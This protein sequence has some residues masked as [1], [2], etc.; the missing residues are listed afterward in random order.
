MNAT[1]ES[2]P[3]R[4]IAAG[5]LDRPWRRLAW[6]VPLAV[7]LWAALLTAFG[8]LLEGTAPPPPELAPAEV[9]IIELP[10]AA[11]LTAGAAPAQPR[12][13]PAVVQPPAVVRPRTPHM[14]RHKLLPEVTPSENGTAKSTTETPAAST[15]AAPAPTTGG[16]GVGGVSGLGTDNDGARAILAPT[17]VIP[18]DLREQEL[19]AV[20]I[21]HFK[22][23]YDGGVT[24][25]LTKPTESPRLNQILLDALSQWR[26]FPA[27]KN[28][29]AIDSEFDVRIP[30]TVD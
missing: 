11:R 20:A 24:V 10:P 17:P 2:A 30:V 13:A 28:G 26:F 15:A 3:A 14:I 18:D 9:R 1:L 19:N 8:I 4:M 5:E 22:V 21:A 7:I 23:A 16:A 27:H 6:V 12:P 25:T 29:V